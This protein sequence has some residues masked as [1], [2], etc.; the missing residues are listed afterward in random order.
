MSAMND[1]QKALNVV[2]RIEQKSELDIRLDT[3]AIITSTANDIVNDLRKRKP[4]KPAALSKVRP[5]PIPK[6]TAAP[7]RNPNTQSPSEPKPFTEPERIE[8]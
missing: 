7:V 4:K 3:L 5:L 1:I 2:R 8:K 6:T